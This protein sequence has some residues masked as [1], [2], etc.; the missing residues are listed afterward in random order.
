MPD[1]TTKDRLRDAGRDRLDACQAELVRLRHATEAM[2]TLAEAMIDE[3]TELFANRSSDHWGAMIDYVGELQDHFEGARSD[4]EVHTEAMRIFGEDKGSLASYDAQARL[5]R[6]SLTEPRDHLPVAAS[7]SFTL[8]Q[9]SL[10]GERRAA[11]RVN[12]FG[13]VHSR[14]TGQAGGACHCAQV[15]DG[16]RLDSLCRFG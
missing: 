12:E 9:K 5:P 3:A 10:N 11:I 6:H 4:V 8:S 16:V 13:L 1:T 7:T 2:E 14:E 15:V